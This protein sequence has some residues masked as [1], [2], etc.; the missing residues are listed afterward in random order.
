MFFSEV[1]LSSQC[2]LNTSLCTGCFK[3]PPYSDQIFSPLFHSVCL[4]YCH[5]DIFHFSENVVLLLKSQRWPISTLKFKHVS[6]L[7]SKW[8]HCYLDLTSSP[9]G[10]PFSLWCWECLWWGARDVIIDFLLQL[11][12]LTGCSASKRTVDEIT[13]SHLP[14]LFWKCLEVFTEQSPKSIQSEDSALLKWLHAISTKLNASWTI[15]YALEPLFLV[16][17]A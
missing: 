2:C 6:F 15:F 1:S 5:Q 4:N 8:L 17:P 3:M 11:S 7:S 16:S 14:H 12:S 13:F 9:L 10:K